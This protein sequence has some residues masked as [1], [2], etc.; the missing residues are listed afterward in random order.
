MAEKTSRTCTVGGKIKKII[1]SSN[2]SY[3]DKFPARISL[4]LP[5]EVLNAFLKIKFKIGTNF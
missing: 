1:T 5:K 4:H 3:L 2:F